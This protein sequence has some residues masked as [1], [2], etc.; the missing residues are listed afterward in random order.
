MLAPMTETADRMAAL[1]RD[2]C[3]HLVRWGIAV[4][5]TWTRTDAMLRNTLAIGAGWGPARA[6]EFIDRVN[7]LAVASPTGTGDR[8]VRC[9]TA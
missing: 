6:Q 8:N 1:E 3:S 4:M 5:S 7:A 9:S 2:F